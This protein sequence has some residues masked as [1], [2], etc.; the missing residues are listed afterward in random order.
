M[1]SSQS[2]TIVGSNLA[3][4]GLAFLLSR[5]GKKVFLCTNSGPPGGFLAGVRFDHKMFD[6]GLVTFELSNLNQNDQAELDSYQ[7]EIRNDYARFLRY[8]YFFFDC[9]GL[10][11]F[12]RQ[13]PE[14][15]FKGN[16]L[17]D[18]ISGDRLSGL[19]LISPI[20]KEAIAQDLHSIV[21]TG[22]MTLHPRNKNFNPCYR[23]ASL[24]TVSLINHGTTFHYQFIEPF[25][26]KTFSRHTAEL[27]GLYHR[28]LWVPLF[29]PETLKSA[30]VGG[31]C[32]IPESRF[33]GIKGGLASDVM[34][35]LM[36]VI[37]TEPSIKVNSRKISLIRTSVNGQIR[38][39]F[40]DNTSH[41]TGKMV[42]ANEP[43]ELKRYITGESPPQI[44]RSQLGILF[45]ELL[46]SDLVRD[47]SSILHTEPKHPFFRVS[48]QSES[49]HLGPDDTVKLSFEFNPNSLPEH[50]PSQVAEFAL[51]FLKELD[52]VRYEGQFTGIW[53]RLFPAAVTLPTETNLQ[54]Y[55]ESIAWVKESLSGLYRMGNSVDF[56]S[57]SINEQ[58][59]Q[60][61]YMAQV[62]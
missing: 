45:A 14:L 11:L 20:L 44:E 25:V 38:L 6:L 17:P 5:R 35:A 42:W 33:F 16:L 53:L 57:N 36:R 41:S 28:V 19:N 47:F 4:F 23:K 22:T 9:L 54:S 52:I 59:I 29:Y 43:Y 27:V 21:N 37:N 50:H 18:F 46:R 34:N 40:D 48:N 30:V 55:S 49:V 2:I 12:E 58:I 39:T 56:A 51:E 10:K 31:G 3:A 62:L 8:V 26:Q 7:P 60:A 15:L 13:K 61:Y 24:E 32:H 1:K